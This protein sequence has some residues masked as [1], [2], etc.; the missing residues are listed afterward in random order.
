MSMYAP[1]DALPL[2]ARPEPELEVRDEVLGRLESLRAS[3][4][5]RIRADLEALYHTRRRRARQ[6]GE[7]PDAVYVT[8]TDARELFEHIPNVPPPEELSR[9]FL[10]AVFRGDDWEAIGVEPST[11]PGRRGALIRRWRYRGTSNTLGPGERG[12]ESA[13]TGIPPAGGDAVRPRDFPHPG[14]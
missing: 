14:A 9:N 4:V 12:R 5:V 6:A 1:L 10:G 3:Y 8:S 13:R 11:T 2:F 7:N